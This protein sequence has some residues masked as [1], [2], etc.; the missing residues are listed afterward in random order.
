MGEQRYD[1][2][3]L[4]DA[5][6][7]TFGSQHRQGVGAGPDMLTPQ[8]IYVNNHSDQEELDQHAESENGRTLEQYH[9]LNKYNTSNSRERKIQNQKQKLT[10]QR[11]SKMRKKSREHSGGDGLV[12]ADGQGERRLHVSVSELNVGR[13]HSAPGGR[14]PKAGGASS[15]TQGRSPQRY[16]SQS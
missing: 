1:A 10:R 16:T 7:E 2:G 4:A 5:G 3:E 6:V 11:H 9:N 12:E 8:N 14:G 15:A 13:K